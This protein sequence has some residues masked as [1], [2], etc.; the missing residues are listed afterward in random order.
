MVLCSLW[1]KG[2]KREWKINSEVKN[3][4]NEKEI[5]AHRRERKSR[6]E[7][8]NPNIGLSG[9]QESPAQCLVT[10]NPVLLQRWCT[11]KITRGSCL[12]ADSIPSDL[13]VRFCRSNQLPGDAHTA[14]RESKWLL[15]SLLITNEMTAWSWMSLCSYFMVN[16]KVSEGIYP[17]ATNQERE[18]SWQ[19]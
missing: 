13:G 17:D 8:T 2:S 19:L 6:S 14:G 11:H 10:P 12:N 18:N 7:L 1:L 15:S 4:T 5:N 9:Y 16:E 3:N